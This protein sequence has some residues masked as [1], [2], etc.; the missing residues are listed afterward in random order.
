MLLDENFD[1]LDWDNANILDW[2]YLNYLQKMI[3]ER[4]IKIGC[5]PCDFPDYASPSQ[6]FKSFFGV[7]FE[8]NTIVWC[9]QRFSPGGFITWKQ[10]QMIYSMTL[11]LATHVYL[12]EDNLKEEN[13]DNG[14][15][16]TFLSYTMPQLIELTGFD[17]YEH[18]FIPGQPILYYNKFLKPLK[19]IL[20]NLKKI[21]SN[22]VDT[23]LNDT[24]C[25]TLN[26][27]PDEY[28]VDKTYAEQLLIRKNKDN[29]ITAM[30]EKVNDGTYIDPGRS[31]FIYLGYYAL[32]FY[33]ERVWYE[34]DSSS[35][36]GD[37]VYQSFT[38]NFSKTYRFRNSF[39]PNTNYDIYLISTTNN[40]ESYQ[41]ASHSTPYMNSIKPYWHSTN[42]NNIIK[43]KSGTIPESGLL[44]ERLSLPDWNLK[45]D[46]PKSEEYIKDNLFKYK[47]TYNSQTDRYDTE[48]NNYASLNWGTVGCY[49]Y[50][51]VVL[52]YSSYFL[53]M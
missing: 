18:P 46:F 40:F 36:I 49:Y 35:I 50:P 24:E 5:A 42:W 10:I 28:F 12:N 52:D 30:Q 41:N 3:H 14:D 51:L 43:V 2:R 26:R 4:Y 48:Y 21:W 1:K 25:K 39:I 22:N 33:D 7:E 11:F 8:K 53:Y 47:Y 15:L 38:V 6:S 16:K 45:I 34:D 17:F 31:Y 9:P 27:L 32:F 44:V 29:W 20:S 37:C 13:F 19:I 23:T